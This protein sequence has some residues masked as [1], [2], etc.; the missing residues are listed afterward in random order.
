MKALQIHSEESLAR[1]K[2]MSVE[3]ILC[4]LEEFRL[5]HGARVNQR[6]NESDPSNL[7]KRKSANQTNQEK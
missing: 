1:S 6:I 7:F 3:E 2:N 4:F 5:L